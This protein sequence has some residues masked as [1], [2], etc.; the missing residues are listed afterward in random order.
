MVVK[1]PVSVV[2]AE[3]RD[4]GL[5]GKSVRPPSPQYGG[6]RKVTDFRVKLL[7]VIRQRRNGWRTVAT[8]TPLEK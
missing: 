3:L 5:G 8:I 4:D 6:I 2:E 7:L 1:F